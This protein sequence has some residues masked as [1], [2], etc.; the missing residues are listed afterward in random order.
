VFLLA[1]TDF[2]LCPFYL[3]YLHLDLGSIISP[4]D[5]LYFFLFSAITAFNKL[6]SSSTERLFHLLLL[7]DTTLAPLPFMGISEI[8][9]VFL[10]LLIFFNLILS[11]QKELISAFYFYFDKLLLTSEPI[12][13]EWG[14]AI[15]RFDS[16]A[17]Y[18]ESLISPQGS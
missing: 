18:L 11:L 1:K 9:N 12:N 2:F 8:F 6:G 13:E 14:L 4:Q 15:I 16:D 5:K 7:F 3:F 17:F 10:L